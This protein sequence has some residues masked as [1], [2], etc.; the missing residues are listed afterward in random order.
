MQ[1]RDGA[2]RGDGDRLAR[3]VIESVDKLAESLPAD[4]DDIE[5]ADE[6]LF[7]DALADARE[8]LDSI[9]EQLRAAV[10]A[11]RGSE[12]QAQPALFDAEA[13]PCS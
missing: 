2:P 7:F 12:P 4:L 10:D 8:H 11:Y 5:Q 1:Q 9:V 13:R 3:R 6:G